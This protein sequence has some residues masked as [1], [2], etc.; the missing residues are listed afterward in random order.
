MSDDV[1]SPAMFCLVITAFHN[2]SILPYL[3]YGSHPVFVA[4]SCI[5]TH[6]HT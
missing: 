2:V 4:M 5:G 6:T 1:A 3:D